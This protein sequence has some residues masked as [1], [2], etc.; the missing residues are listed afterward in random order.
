MTTD[1]I[2]RSLEEKS[3]IQ[4]KKI[5]KAKAKLQSAMDELISAEREHA[6]TIAYLD[7]HTLVKNGE[8]K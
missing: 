1:Q 8:L 2:I 4:L 5:E 7:R 6:R 3:Q